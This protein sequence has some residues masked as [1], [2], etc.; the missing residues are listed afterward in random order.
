MSVRVFRQSEVQLMASGLQ[1]IMSHLGSGVTALG[2]H[3]A[4]SKAGDGQG[5][6]WG[7]GKER[8]GGWGGRKKRSD[9]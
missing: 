8:G 4:K 6:F 7:M 2:T 9:C 1:S 5:L 3:F